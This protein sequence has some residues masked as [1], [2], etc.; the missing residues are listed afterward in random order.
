MS[1]TPY[2]SRSCLP[3]ITISALGAVVTH[4]LPARQPSL[5][6]VAW[7]SALSHATVERELHHGCH[8]LVELIAAGSP[9]AAWAVDR[10]RA[11]IET[12]ALGSSVQAIAHRGL[13][14]AY[15]TG[16][17]IA[18]D[19]AAAARHEALG[20]G[21]DPVLRDQRLAHR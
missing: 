16:H 10:L 17:G 1:T 20:G 12:P 14:L 6:G 7:G 18:V 21:G 11:A 4:A 3:L 9:D 13:A 19:V 15:R 2:L 5:T 8:H